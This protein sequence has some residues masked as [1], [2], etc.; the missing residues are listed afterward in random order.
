M[1]PTRR[2]WSPW[3]VM[4]PDASIFFSACPTDLDSGT[5]EF[6]TVFVVYLLPLVPLPDSGTGLDETGDSE[7]EKRFKVLDKARF[8]LFPGGVG[9]QPVDHAGPFPDNTVEGSGIVPFNNASFGVRGVPVYFRQF[10]R[11]GAGHGAVAAGT[12]K[13]NGIL[14]RRLVQV[15][16]EWP[17]LFRQVVFGP[18]VTGDPLT[19]TQLFSLGLDTVVEILERGE[20]SQLQVP[21]GPAPDVLVRIVETGDDRF[22]L[23]LI[24][25]EAR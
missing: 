2:R 16:P 7:R 14:R 1:A 21:A 11:Q 6:F 25:L 9:N 5:G 15:P 13:D 3:P 10:Q 17:S 20:V 22:P 18:A 24:L 23:R 19:G 4:S 12:G 8:Q